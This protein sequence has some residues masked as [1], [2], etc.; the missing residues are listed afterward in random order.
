MSSGAIIEGFNV[1]EDHSLS[2]Q[3]GF[4]Y[5]RIRQYY[6]IAGI[7]ATTIRM[8]KTSPLHRSAFLYFFD[9]IAYTLAGQRIRQIPAD[10][11]SGEQIYNNTQIQPTFFCSQIGNVRDKLLPGHF[12]R[13][14]P[15]QMIWSDIG[16]SPERRLCDAGST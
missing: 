2:I 5:L 15:G 9:G 16:Q 11:N 12:R 14:R 3:F 1:I 4:K 8:K 6:I 7:L 13:S 10:N